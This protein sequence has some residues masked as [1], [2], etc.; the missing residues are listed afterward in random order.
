M[1]ARLAWLVDSKSPS[2]PDSEG[3]RPKM[4]LGKANSGPGRRP[5][6]SH[7][8]HPN[9]PNQVGIQARESFP[10]EFHAK[11]IDGPVDSQKSGNPHEIRGPN[12]IGG[13]STAIPR[14][15]I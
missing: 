8:R 7:S 10:S 15:K 2:A 9:C 6:R 12:S 4:G 5:K 1:L 13:G 3:L 14:V 11:V